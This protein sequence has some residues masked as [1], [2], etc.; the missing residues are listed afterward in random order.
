MRACHRI[1]NS[2]TFFINKAGA[3]VDSK[4]YYDLHLKLPIT[5]FIFSLIFFRPSLLSFRSQNQKPVWTLVVTT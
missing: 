2:P 5:F 1:L 3:T 4:Q